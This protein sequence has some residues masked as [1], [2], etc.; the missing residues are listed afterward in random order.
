MSAK[1]AAGA[2]VYAKDL[3]GLARFYAGICG[4]PVVQQA[5]DHALLQSEH[6][7]L[8]LHALPPA[9]AAEIEIGSPP[10]RREEQ[11]IKLCFR[12]AS[13]AGARAVAAGLGGQVDGPER[14]WVFAGQRVCDG[15][16]PEGNV[17]QLRELLSA[18]MD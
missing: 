18:L 15:H 14:E 9:I 4:L 3:Q 7:Q 17:I 10:Q 8:V 12:V 1:F 5:A 2:V 13:I 16:D 6:F 11:A